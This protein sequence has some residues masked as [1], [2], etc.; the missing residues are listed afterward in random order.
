MSRPKISSKEQTLS[1]LPGEA[2]CVYIMECGWCGSDI[3]VDADTQQ[4]AHKAFIE[5]GVR[6]VDTDD[7]TGLFCAECV[8]AARKNKLEA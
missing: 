7:V 5:Q 8:E 1:M 6:E 4:E 3:E 2:R